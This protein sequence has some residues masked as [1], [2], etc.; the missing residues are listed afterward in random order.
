MVKDTFIVYPIMIM[1]LFVSLVKMQLDGICNSIK[2][3]NPTL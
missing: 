1:L 3:T 2:S